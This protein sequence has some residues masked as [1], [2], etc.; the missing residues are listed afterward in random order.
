MNKKKSFIFTGKESD[1]LMLN[2]NEC[3]HKAGNPKSKPRSQIMLQLN[4]SFNWTKD[5]KLYEKQFHLEPKFPLLDYLFLNKEKIQ[6]K[7]NHFNFSFK[8]TVFSFY[9]RI[10]KLINI[11]DYP[12]KR[13]NS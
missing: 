12:S 13:K 2:P 4:P 10:S 8:Y 1:L 6:W 11:Y 3:F 9:E 5:K 7:V